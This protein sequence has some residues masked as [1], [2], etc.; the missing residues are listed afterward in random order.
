MRASDH[1]LGR[2]AAADEE[3]AVQ[4]GGFMYFQDRGVPTTQVYDECLAEI[5]LMEALGYDEVWLAEH[6]FSPYGLLP[7]PNLILANL[8]ARTRRIRLGNMVSVLPFYQPLRLAEEIAMLDHLTH[9]RLNVGIGSG[10]Q[11]EFGRYGVPFE[12]AKPRFYEAVEVLWK[13]FTTERFDHHGQF[14][15][16]P[17]ATLM[18]RP[19][20]QPYPP[21]FVAATS[22]DTV[23]WCAEH[24]LPIAQMW[25]HPADAQ[26]NAATYRQLL[27]RDG[28]D[29]PGRPS[30]RLFRAVYVAE[31]TEQALAEAEPELYRFFQLFYGST[32]PRYRTPS[33]EGWRHHVGTALRRLGPLDFATLDAENLIVVGD[34]ARVREKV[35]RLQAE[36]GLDG[37]VGIF[38][39]GHLTHAQV[40]RSLRLFATEVLPAFRAAP[41]GAPA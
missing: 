34:P 39:F 3:G 25:I 6:H 8:A 38:A 32:D 21:F 5:E 12:E 7:S 14:Y 23:R 27:A 2:G 18:P 20:Q 4:F 37:F 41:A 16:Y 36:I 13:A 35:A 29:G 24:G 30:V 28:A 40:C 31:T 10:V 15:H 1:G 22:P 17:N 26:R 19:L 9:G 11:R 33:P